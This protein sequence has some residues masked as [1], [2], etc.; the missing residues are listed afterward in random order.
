MAALRSQLKELSHKARGRFYFLSV[1]YVPVLFIS[2][3][4]LCN[5]IKPHSAV[6]FP[7]QVIII[8]SLNF[9]RMEN[10]FRWM[11]GMENGEGSG[12]R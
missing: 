7:L 2:S 5:N 9:H 8:R 11:K 4:L 6:D 12:K 1:P 10:G 3:R